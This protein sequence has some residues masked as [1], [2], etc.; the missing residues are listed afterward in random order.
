MHIPPGA[1]GKSGSRNATLASKE[2]FRFRVCQD[3]CEQPFRVLRFIRHEVLHELFIP[4]NR[5]KWAHNPLLN[6]SIHVKVDQIANVN[7]PT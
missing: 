2:L 4:R 1:M 3:Q 6:F 5:E 7:V